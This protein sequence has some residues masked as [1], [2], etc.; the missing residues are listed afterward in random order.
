MVPAAPGQGPHDAEPQPEVGA[1]K[2]PRFGAC[3]LA[4][5]ANGVNGRAFSSSGQERRYIV[6][7][8]NSLRPGV[9]QVPLPTRRKTGHVQAVPPVLVPVPPSEPAIAVP[10]GYVLAGARGLPLQSPLTQTRPRDI[11]PAQVLVRL[12]AR[13]SAIL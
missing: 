12:T 1:G 4:L 13:K 3:Q 9:S 2:S 11:H 8:A 5:L 6:S 7:A 10:A